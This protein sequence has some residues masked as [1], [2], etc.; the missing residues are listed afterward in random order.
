MRRI[1]SLLVL[2]LLCQSDLS[3]QVVSEWRGFGRSGVYNETG[4]LTEWPVGGPKLLWSIEGLPKGYSSVVIANS[5]IYTTGFKGDSD[6]LIAMDLNGNIKWQ[7]PYG[8]AWTDSYPESRCTPTVVGNWVYV[9]SGKGDLACFNALNGESKWSRKASEDYHGDYGKWGLS[10][11]LLVVGDKVFFTP[12]GETT[13]MIALDKLSGK[14]VW[15]T[16]SLKDAPSYTSPLLVE[17]G[18]KKIIV[19]VTTKY[20]F[21]ANALDGKILWKFDFGLYAEERNNNTNTPIY[22]E[23]NIFL[24][25]GYNHKS[26]MLRL[27]EDGAHVTL[28]WVEGILDVHHGGVVKV[29]DYIYGSSW[30]HNT[31][32][33]W[34]C[35]EWNTGKMMYDKEWI[36]KGSII[37]AEGMLYCYEEKSGNIALVK[38]S[39]NDFKVISSFKISKGSG[40]HWA[41]PV[42]DNGVLYIRHGEALMAYSILK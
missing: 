5:M 2:W 33:N 41:H 30:E 23:G 38:A 31:M 21:G 37:S 24:T 11:S 6:V 42:I 36:N 20:I 32:G 4:L 13:T 26:I 22:S 12:G 7:N 39:P 40:P 19:N 25:S 15:I 17:R 35:L 10:E 9:S 14:T 16:E 1:I 34:V 18:G 3:A 28:V 27:T 29:G 8:R